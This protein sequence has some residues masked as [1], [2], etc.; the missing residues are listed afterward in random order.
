M[1]RTG[2]AARTRLALLRASGG[3]V[4][5]AGFLI[6]SMPLQAGAAVT[7]VVIDD[8]GGTVLGTRTVTPLGA[9]RAV[10]RESP[11]FAQSDGVATLLVPGKGTTPTGVVL[12]YAFDPTD[13]T[14]GGSNDTLR[15]AFGSRGTRRTSIGPVSVS[16]W[17][18]DSA[19]ATGSYRTTVPAGGDDLSIALSC[20]GSP[21]ACVSSDVDLTKATSLR[22]LVSAAAGEP[23]TVVLDDVRTVP[24]ALPSTPPTAPPQTPMPPDL[25][26]GSPAAA[27]S[28]PAA[29]PTAREP[30]AGAGPSS[31]PTAGP[32]SP[33][34][35]T[36]TGTATAPTQPAA[37][38]TEPA[39]PRT[40][41][42]T[43]Q[44]RAP[45][46]TSA[47]QAVMSIGET[48]EVVVV[49]DGTPTATLSATDLP[50]GLI[51][52]DHGN[53][54]AT[55]SG[56]PAFDGRTVVRLTATNA[57]GRADQALSI[58]VR[59]APIF[60]NGSSA[61]FE[62]GA[63][64]SFDVR[65]TGVPV[66]KLTLSAGSLPPG[67]TLTDNNDGTATIAGTPTANGGSTTVALTATN[68]AGS[69]DYTLTIVVQDTPVFTSPAAVRFTAG[70]PRSFTVTTSG[71]P[72]PTIVVDSGLPAWLAFDDFGDGTGVLRTRGPAPSGASAVVELRALNAV[73]ADAVQRVR[74]AVR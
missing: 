1:V 47:D 44:P 28:A 6:G 54:T 73:G 20:G 26:P 13:L 60:T 36:P 5:L 22:L 8:F 10:A 69:T 31:G 21:A 59:S 15:V 42:P 32:T 55:I 34:E 40:A 63:P 4:V 58:E 65:T 27:A 24:G 23:T 38:T 16:V 2:V 43:A 52:V 41:A 37:P 9:T 14:V 11:G 66:P 3:L 72:T 48:G 57:A 35:P 74:V 61:T 64:G 68:A 53:G 12:D 29:S 50:V 49:A 45:L 39:D 46:F 67:L 56:T 33:A 70:A 25:G 62:R 17:I 71:I 7:S 18:T 51:F 19:A 30:E